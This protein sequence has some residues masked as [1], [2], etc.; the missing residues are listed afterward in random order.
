MASSSEFAVRHPFLDVGDEVAA[1]LSHGLAVVAL[2]STIISH[3]MPYPQNLATARAVEQVVRDHGAVPATIALIKGRLRVGLDDA[4]LEELA[5]PGDV[6]K[7]SRRDLAAL[8]AAGATAGTTVAATM[9]VAAAAG[10]GVFATGGIGGV[11]RGADQTFDVSA[12]LIELGSTP[13]T[14]VCAGA[15]SILDLPKTLEVLETYGVPVIGVGTDEFPAFFSRTSGLPV[16]H[17][18]E[19]AGELARLVDAQ[20]RL[21]LA[22]GVLV[23][24]PIPEADA[25]APDEIDGIIEQALTDADEQGVTGKDVTPYLLARVN[26]LTGGRSLTANV[27]LIRNNAAFAADLAVE[28]T[29]LSAAEVGGVAEGLDVDR[30]PGR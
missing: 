29:G 17:R 11:H 20:R 23:A 28:L 13:V 18:V 3:G 9:Y 27:A 2:E 25:L 4:A 26:E 24:H 14:V 12:D 10:I 8:V 30:D 6:A 19:S 16:A 22:Q 7:A 5:R 1:A 15:K 21:G